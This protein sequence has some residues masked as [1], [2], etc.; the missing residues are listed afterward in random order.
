VLEEKILDKIKQKISQNQ[1]KSANLQFAIKKEDGQWKIAIARLVFD[2][3]E[4]QQNKI[5]VVYEDFRLEDVCLSISKALEFLEYLAKSNINNVPVV[6]SIPQIT[7]EHYFEL[8]QY[9]LCFAGNFTSD[10]LYFLSRDK[11]KDYHG[12]G[13][14]VFETFYSLPQFILSKTYNRLDLSSY[15]IPFRNVAEAVNHFWGTN[16][17]TYQ[18]AN[19]NF[20]L[21]LPVYDASIVGCKIK[22]KHVKLTLDINQERAKPE[23]LSVG[24]IAE[25]ETNDFRD[26]LNVTGDI[27]EFDLSLIPNTAYFSLSKG[28]ERLD[29]YHW[30]SSTEKARIDGIMTSISREKTPFSK[31]DI[32]VTNLPPKETERKL[33]FDHNIVEKL[34]EVVQALLF[35]AR[36]SCNHQLYRSTAILFR[37]TLEE[38]VTIILRKSG[39]ENELVNERG[40]E[41]SLEG[42]IDLL[43]KLPDGFT[44]MKDDLNIVKWFGDK[45][46][47]Q[48]L[49]P[50]YEKDIL[51]NLEPKMRL[52]LVKYIEYNLRK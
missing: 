19:N 11:S 28:N 45:A 2:I 3:Q 38:L 13:R 20:H 32:N 17:D 1:Y 25:D 7:D 27:L 6:N 44:K 42:K 48:A 43:S 40:Y 8:G 10:D 41:L 5:H 12:I 50:V 36:E 30:Q 39:K 24:V 51:D 4:P 37:T 35:E 22:D 49:M 46:T 16:Y 34:P 15:K 47:H 23:E 33:E 52:F 31:F 26:R 29:E 14:P 21:Y 18:M 9:K